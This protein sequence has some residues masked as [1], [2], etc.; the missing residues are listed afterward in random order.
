ME[1]YYKERFEA[2]SRLDEKIVPLVKINQIL[3]EMRDELRTLIPTAME[4]RILLMDP[5][6]KKYTRPL[7][8]ILYDRPVNCLSCKRSRPVIKK[9]LEKRGMVVVPESDPIERENGEMVQVGPEAA[10]PAFLGD[11]VLLVVS[12]VGKPGTRFT[13]KDFFLIEDFAKTARNVVLRAKIH[14]EMTEEKLRISKMLSQISLF[15]PQSVL[16]IAEK[17]PAILSQEKEKKEVS[18]LFLDIEGYTELSA[19]LPEQEVNQIV[20]SLFSSFVD[21]IHRSQG[22]INETAGD[23]L[24]IIFKEDDI[25]TNAVNSIKAAF[26]IHQQSL[27]YNQELPPHIEPINVNMGIH[28]GTA[29]VGMTRFKG[30]IGTRMTYTASGNVTNL[31]ARLADQARGGDILIA[32]ETRNLVQGL[33]P[34]FDRGNAVLKGIEKPVHIYSLLRSG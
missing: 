29:L 31:A 7:Q 25:K 23:G 24:M 12:V 1:R 13:P 22:D 9:A 16:K 26:D 8:C 19:K 32:D 11:E 28:C 17:D 33:W 27:S 10:A 2:R 15:V 4:A 6:A 21:P 14:W 20:E 30:S 3:Q 18:I 34:V 5:D